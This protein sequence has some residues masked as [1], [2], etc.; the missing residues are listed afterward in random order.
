MR[1][2]RL[3]LAALFTLS[4]AGAGG[5]RKRTQVEGTRAGAGELAPLFRGYTRALEL[6]PVGGGPLRL[7][8]VEV[9]SQVCSFDTG[10][11]RFI[12][13]PASREDGK[14]FAFRLE[15][16]AAPFAPAVR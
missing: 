1:P 6:A 12:P 2:H 5:C 4:L 7:A 14:R 16:D 11:F 10:A 13:V 8:S 9:E 3:A 15:D